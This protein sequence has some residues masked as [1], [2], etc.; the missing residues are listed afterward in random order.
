MNIVLSQNQLYT[1]IGQFFQYLG[2]PLK[3]HAISGS[4][5]PLHS[6]TSMISCS[7]PEMGDLVVGA[8]VFRFSFVSSFVNQERN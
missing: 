8:L 1:K 5:I 3:L 2:F 6:G 4:D 7:R